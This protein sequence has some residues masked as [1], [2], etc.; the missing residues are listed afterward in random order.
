M[1][2]TSIRARVALVSA[3][4]AVLLVGGVTVGTY[5]LVSTGMS[6]TAAIASARLARSG[7][8]AIDG[9]VEDMLAE[10]DRRGLSDVETEAYV[11]RT[12]IGAAPN[13]VSAGL[14]NEAMYSLFVWQDESV[15]PTLAWSVGGS[16]PE[17]SAAERLEAAEQGR[18]VQR[19]SKLRP[20][21]TSMLFRADL[22][23]YVT[24]IP[25]E[26]P[27][28]ARA[29]LEVDY[30]AT[31]EEATL[32]ST[33]LP[34]TAVALVSL[35]MALLIASM[36]TRWTLSL[37]GDL[38][39]TADSVDIGRLDV[40]LPEEGK[41]EVAELARSLNRL[42]GNLQRR[43]EA[44]ARFIAD[45]SH[46][47]ATPVA[48]IRGYVNILRA[49]GAEDPAL[50]EEAVSAIDRE[51][52]R[53]ARLCSDL[54]SVIRNEELVEYRQIRY[55]INATCREVVAN[56]ATRYFDKHLDY[57]G[58]EEGPLWLHGDP[59]RIE[60]ALGILVDNACKYTPSGGKV[61]VTSRRY[62]DR[63]VVDVTDTGEGIPED[64]LPSIFERFYRSDTSRSKETGGFGLGLAIAQHIV[65]ASGG[66]I[67]V[68]SKIGEGT[69]FSV[70]L[71]RQRSRS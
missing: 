29:V 28:V 44:Q 66:E 7:Q 56:A 30:S 13:P 65:D 22:G 6:R 24:D 63:I 20:L 9:V 59:D 42:I 49:W 60:E 71:P 8:L 5:M 26:I 53:M 35:V 39:R 54:L 1:R 70:S 32:D 36:T 31:E 64:D 45:A 16:G 19:T 55:D 58:P 37:V 25:V 27:G 52:R 33:R 11:A 57:C 47:L 50:R 17:E 67:S 38:R 23:R 41:T 51:S 21:I 3:V 15:G 4:Y 61:S 40:R 12:L 68:Q 46:E 10:A 69:T 14:A 48:G 43:N 62:R 34:M 2:L 18:M